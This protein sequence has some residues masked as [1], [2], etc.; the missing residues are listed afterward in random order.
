MLL[1]LRPLQRSR[2]L[3][4][5]PSRRSSVLSWYLKGTVTLLSIDCEP[6][7]SSERL[8]GMLSQRSLLSPVYHRTIHLVSDGFQIQ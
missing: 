1:K 8:V 6:D 7:H 2:N 4:S 5:T 3:E